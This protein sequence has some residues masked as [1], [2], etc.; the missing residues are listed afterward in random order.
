VLFRPCNGSIFSGS[1]YLLDDTEV[2]QMRS[3]KEEKLSIIEWLNGRRTHRS[4]PLGSAN[5]TETLA[6]IIDKQVERQR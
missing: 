6:P 4:A 3:Q 2:Y 1:F 5:R